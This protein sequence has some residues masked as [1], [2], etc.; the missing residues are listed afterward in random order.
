[1]DAPARPEACPAAC[2]ASII[3]SVRARPATAAAGAVRRKLRRPEFSMQAFHMDFPP[4]NSIDT[5]VGPLYHCSVLHWQVI[6]LKS[7][8]SYVRGKTTRRG[9]RALPPDLRQ[10]RKHAT[11]AGRIRR[12]GLPSE[13]RTK[14]GSKKT[15]DL[16]ITAIL[17][18]WIRF[19]SKWHLAGLKLDW[20]TG[21]EGACRAGRLGAAV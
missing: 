14:I 17:P 13:L 19:G 4:E 20:D 6:A 10:T 15:Y 21:C 2:A 5:L 11:K 18:H 9:F 1:M 7:A 3:K 12:C 16:A 8:R